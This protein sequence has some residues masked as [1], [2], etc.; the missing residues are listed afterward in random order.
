KPGYRFHARRVIEVLVFTFAITYYIGKHHCAYS[1]KRKAIAAKACSYIYVFGV[2]R[3]V[4]YIWQAIGWFVV[5]AAPL[6][7]YRLYIEE[8]PY[9]CLKLAEAFFGILFMRRFMV[10]ATC[11]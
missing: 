11:Y 4:A 8:L 3:Q 2:A 9:I 5:L 7:G 1:A 10:F 6:K